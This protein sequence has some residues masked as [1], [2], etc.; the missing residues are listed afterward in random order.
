M[1]HIYNLKL[2]PFDL[3]LQE[4]RLAAM[5]KKLKNPAKRTWNHLM[6]MEQSKI[7]TLNL[8]IILVKMVA[9]FQGNGFSIGLP[10]QPPFLIFIIVFEGY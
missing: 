6:T 5:E 7:R 8:Q 2:Q 10:Y 4:S 1:R 9:D 3:K